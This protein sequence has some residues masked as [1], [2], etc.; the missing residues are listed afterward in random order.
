MGRRFWRRAIDFDV[1][2]EEGA[3]SPEDLQLMDVV[4]TA[5]EAWKIIRDFYRMPHPFSTDSYNGCCL[6]G[7]AA[8]LS[9]AERDVLWLLVDAL[10]GILCRS[11]R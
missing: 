8:S 1:L 9:G 11:F 2:V 3:I 7:G 5:E 4:E 6:P 10:C